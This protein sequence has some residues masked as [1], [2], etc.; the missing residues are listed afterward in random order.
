MG[1]SAR[2]FIGKLFVPGSLSHRPY[3]VSPFSICF[4]LYAQFTSA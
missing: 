2:F 3:S 4:Q 1:H